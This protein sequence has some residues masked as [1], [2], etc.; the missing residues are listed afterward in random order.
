MNMENMNFGCNMLKLSKF[1]LLKRHFV[2]IAIFQFVQK[3]SS[4]YKL[5]K[6]VKTMYSINQSKTM[7][8]QLRSR[9]KTLHVKSS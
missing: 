3:P 7:K 9:I 4:D 5:T 8:E 1:L 2:K 6:S